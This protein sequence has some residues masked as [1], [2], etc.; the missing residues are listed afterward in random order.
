MSLLH[1]TLKTINVQR[2]TSLLSSNRGE[3]SPPFLS[4]FGRTG[5]LLL[6]IMA[7]V[8]LR[9]QTLTECSLDV[10]LDVTAGAEG[11]RL[12]SLSKFAFSQVGYCCLVFLPAV[13]W[14][15]FNPGRISL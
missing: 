2:M 10:Q 11:Q 8:P 9:M 12:V 7:W 6:I 5:H 3:F 14:K 1:C 4:W 13:P 15:V